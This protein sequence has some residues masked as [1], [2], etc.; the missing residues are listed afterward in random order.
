MEN[1]SNYEIELQKARNL[2]DRGEY[3]CAYNTLKNLESLTLDSDV[4]SSISEIKKRIST[5]IKE[6]FGLR[7]W[8]LDKGLDSEPDANAYHERALRELEK[9]MQYEREGKLL[10]AQRLAQRTNFDLKMLRETG[11]THG[12][13]NYSRQL[14]FRKAGEPPATLLDYLPDDFVTFVDESHMTIPQ[15]R[16]MYAGDRARKQTLVEH[17]F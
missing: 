1:S 14:S 6:K 9:A 17:G 8:A 7:P 3:V 5:E 13:E 15:I 10:E 4:S 2:V 11:Y 16:G 12:I